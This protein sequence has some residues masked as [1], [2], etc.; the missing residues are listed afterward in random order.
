MAHP[1]PSTAPSCEAIRISSE[2]DVL[3]LELAETS[4]FEVLRQGIRN[5]FKEMET[6]RGRDARLDFGKRK[7]DLFDL[8]RLAHVLKD[9]FD[10]TV[11][12]LFCE[13]ESLV[14]F[15]ERELK[16]KVH[17]RTPAPLAVDAPDADHLETDQDSS[18]IQPTGPVAVQTVATP[19][20]VEEIS[21]DTQVAPQQNFNGGDT[22]FQESQTEK[23]LTLK[24]SLRSGQKVRYAGDVVIYGDINPGAEVIAGGNILIMGALKGL[25]H[26][27]ARGD[28]G[29]LIIAF[30]FRPTQI[31]IGRKIAI[32][33]TREIRAVK[34]YTPEIAWVRGG[35]ILIEPYAGHLPQ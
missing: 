30:D 34:T 8:R 11:A 33:P 9:E 27:G 2:D 29:A 3:V 4:S 19:S 17:P 22:L 7:I 31:R 15:A 28:D 25:C 23:V 12:A 20:L 10:V 5:R 14:Q 6:W 1:L 21:S 35:E 32:P 18:E 26:A 16:L 13:Q 24:R